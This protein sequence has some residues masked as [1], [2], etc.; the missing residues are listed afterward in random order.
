M[1]RTQMFYLFKREIVRKKQHFCN[2][3]VDADVNVDADTEMSMPWFPND[4]LMAASNILWWKCIMFI[5][6]SK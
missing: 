1:Y 3:D 2:F 4:H 6:I 5:C